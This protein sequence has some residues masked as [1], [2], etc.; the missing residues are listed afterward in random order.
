MQEIFW[1]FDYR[2][3]LALTS[4]SSLFPFKVVVLGR[5]WLFWIFYFW[6]CYS[7]YFVLSRYRSMKADVHCCRSLK[8][9]FSVCRFVPLSK[10]MIRTIYFNWNYAFLSYL[11]ILFF[12]SIRLIFVSQVHCKVLHTWLFYFLC[13]KYLKCSF[14]LK[15]FLISVNFLTNNSLMGV[16]FI[17]PGVYNG[18]S[19][20]NL[21]VMVYGYYTV[22]KM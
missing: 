19:K 2:R 14:L 6:N 4:I 18:L 3:R 12:L 7:S 13:V 1:W 11:L 9:F 8:I 15:I 5:Y 21:F 16:W 20:I 17:R 22:V 10:I